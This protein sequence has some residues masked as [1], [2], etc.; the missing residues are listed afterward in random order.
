MF[1]ENRNWEETPE[2]EN[3]SHQ[4]SLG[5]TPY[6]LTSHADLIQRGADLQALHAHMQRDGYK[7]SD[8]VG[9]PYWD[10]AHVYIDSGGE[11][12]LG[13][14]GNHRI[15]IAR[16]LGLNRIPVLLGGIHK[17]FALNLG[18][19]NNLL[20]KSTEYIIEKFS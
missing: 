6:G 18:D 19:T 4:L 20:G 2:F 5:L 13:R 11:L 9:S 16:A 10:E 1:V 15:A 8:E 7:Q 17:N 12:C 3:F 14:H